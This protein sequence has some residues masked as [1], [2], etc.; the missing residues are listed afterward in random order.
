MPYQSLVNKYVI[1]VIEAHRAE[2]RAAQQQL[3][4]KWLERKTQ[5]E[6]QGIPFNE[7]PPQV[8]GTETDQ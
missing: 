2:G 1:P 8:N 6:S 4:T 5:A 7:P 3:W